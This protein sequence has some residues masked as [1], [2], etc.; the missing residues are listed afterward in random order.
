MGLPHPIVN[1]MHTVLYDKLSDIKA[2]M[3]D[4]TRS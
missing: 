2:N 1:E 3:E 4:T